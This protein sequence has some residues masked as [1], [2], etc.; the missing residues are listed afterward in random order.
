MTHHLILILSTRRCICHFT[1]HTPAQSH[2]CCVSSFPGMLSICCHAQDR[3]TGLLPLGP[4]TTW[5]AFQQQLV[6]WLG[7][8]TGSFQ[9]MLACSRASDHDQVQKIPVHEGTV[10]TISAHC[11]TDVALLCPRGIIAYISVY[12]AA[13]STVF[14][15]VWISLQS[16]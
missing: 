12:F 10:S 5:A 3:L 13:D 6:L 4:S 1:L 16:N 14:W 9:V 15:K 2:P 8:P 11:P 7:L